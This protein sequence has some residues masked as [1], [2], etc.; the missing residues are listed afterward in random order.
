MAMKWNPYYSA[1]EDSFEEFLDQ[2]DREL[3]LTF[4]RPNGSSVL[5]GA[6][7]NGEPAS[8]V[9]IANLLLD[10]GACASV[11][12]TDDQINVLHVLF[13]GL[14]EEHDFELEAPLL[15]RLLEGGAD[16]NLWSPRFSVPVECLMSMPASDEE[17]APFYGVVFSW[18][19]I[20]LG[21]VINKHRGTTLRDRLFG[22]GRP[23]LPRLA[24][25][26]GE[27]HPSS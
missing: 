13:S 3:A 25:A 14:A 10:D 5:I 16:I 6:M 7:R 8:R 27:A 22:T 12:T 1:M 26:Y 21:V 11:V 19:G 18:P 9:R 20:D 24:R 4:R 2:Y 23:D 15:R 17:L